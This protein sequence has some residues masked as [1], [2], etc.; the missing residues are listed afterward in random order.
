[1]PLQVSSDGQTDLIPCCIAWF[2]LND[3]QWRIQMG[4][5]RFTPPPHVRPNFFTF[6]QFWVKIGFILGL[7]DSQN[8]SLFPLDPPLIVLDREIKFKCNAA[9]LKF[10][11][12]MSNKRN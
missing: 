11:L 10:V 3:Y 4:R 2:L 5:I 7:L 1:M 9:V 12:Q 6:M 8:Y